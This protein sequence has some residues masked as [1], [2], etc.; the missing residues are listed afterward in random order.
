MTPYC[1]SSLT[2]KS[3]VS[4]GEIMVFINNIVQWVQTLY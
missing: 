4:S 3:V 1:F 2:L